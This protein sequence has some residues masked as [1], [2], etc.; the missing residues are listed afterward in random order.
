MAGFVAKCLEGQEMK[1]VNEA[2]ICGLGLL[3]QLSA[4]VQNSAFRFKLLKKKE[5]TILCSHHPPMYPPLVI[6]MNEEGLHG[7]SNTG[8]H[9]INISLWI[10]YC[11]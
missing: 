1:G 10:C 7:F 9:W 4:A 11:S 2:H 3:Q 8:P 5:I 6:F